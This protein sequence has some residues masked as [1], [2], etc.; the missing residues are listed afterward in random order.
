MTALSNRDVAGTNPI[1]NSSQRPTPT[2][3]HHDGRA[4]GQVNVGTG[5]GY[6][7]S[8]VPIKNGGPGQS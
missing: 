8:N 7:P 6:A 5:G 4:G 1:H 2:E 3:P